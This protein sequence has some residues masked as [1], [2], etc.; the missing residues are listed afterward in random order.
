MKKMLKF[1]IVFQNTC[2]S[3]YCWTDIIF[4]WSEQHYKGQQQQKSTYTYM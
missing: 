3:C 1:Y 2:S 4:D